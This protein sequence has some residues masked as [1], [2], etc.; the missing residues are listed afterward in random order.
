M[1][2]G[3]LLRG[4]YILEVA[5]I[6]GSTICW[7]LPFNLTGSH[8]SIPLFFRQ[9]NAMCF[10]S[11]GRG[12]MLGLLASRGIDRWWR[13]CGVRITWRHCVGMAVERAASESHSI[14]P[15]GG[16]VLN[17]LPHSLVVVGSCQ[18]SLST[19]RTAQ[20]Y[21]CK[22]LIIVYSLN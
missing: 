1:T 7:Y 15:S 10:W 13:I 16:W 9:I 18:I 14:W 11:L 22:A 2:D 3:L 5:V 6:S 4:V 8:I 21:N 19:S 12:H 20:I 17:I